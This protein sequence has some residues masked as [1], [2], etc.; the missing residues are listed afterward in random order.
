MYGDSA[1]TGAF[2]S[3]QALL[4]G[5]LVLSIGGTLGASLLGVP[6]SLIG[7]TFLA[8]FLGSMALAWPS[9]RRGQPRHER[10]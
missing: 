3:A 9:F 8:I 5:V 7:V 2:G 4:V 1:A 10:E 6:N